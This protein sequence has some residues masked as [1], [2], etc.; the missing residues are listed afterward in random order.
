MRI[1]SSVTSVSWLPSEAV[2][3]MPRLPFDVGLAQYDPPPP[4]RLD[5]LYLLRDENAVRAA[6]ELRA[7]IEVEDGRIVA[8]GF[9]GSAFVNPPRVRAAVARAPA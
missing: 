7:W 1:E 6:N 9:D 4:D 2:G 8:H 5:D 3:G